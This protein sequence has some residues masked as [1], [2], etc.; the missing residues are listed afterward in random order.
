MAV[1]LKLNSSGYW[2]AV[3]CDMHKLRFHLRPNLLFYIIVSF[4]E[5]A[6][7]LH[8]WFYYQRNWQYPTSSSN[9][10]RTKLASQYG[11]LQER[12]SNS[13]VERYA[14]EEKEEGDEKSN[15]KESLPKENRPKW[16]SKLHE[17]NVEQFC[18]VH[19][20]TRDLGDNVTAKDRVCTLRRY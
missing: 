17:I 13:D 18:I 19:S 3:K 1:A 8:H 12:G 4:D 16:T 10:A 7:S 14:S 2:K 20:L 15:G 11:W 6:R 9:T 5:R